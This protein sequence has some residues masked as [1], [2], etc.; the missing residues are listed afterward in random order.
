MEI[1]AFTV[2]DW[3]TVKKF[4]HFHNFK[5]N[6]FKKASLP[7]ILIALVISFLG[8]LVCYLLDGIDSTLITLLIVEIVGALILL[9]SWFIMPIISFNINKLAKNSKN[10]FVFKEETLVASGKTDDMSG[11]TEINYKKL[12]CI[13]ETNE[14]LYVYINKNQAFIVE[15]ASVSGGSL[16]E[17]RTH[18]IDKMK[19]GK[20]RFDFN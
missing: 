8:F 1:T 15:K 19:N 17:L 3:K 14:Y 7:I 9:F 4:N 12:D 13:Y 16:E 5:K 18:L 10:E 6:K 2:Y 11:S 20:Y